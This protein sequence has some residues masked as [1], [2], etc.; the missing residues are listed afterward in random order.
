MSHWVSAALLLAV[1]LRQLEKSMR[2]I[3]G[4]GLLKHAASI[5]L[6]AYI[7]S[8]WP[9]FCG[10]VN[11]IPM[12][13]HYGAVKK[14]GTKQHAMWGLRSSIN[15]T[16]HVVCAVLCAASSLGC[17]QLNLLSCI[18]GRKAQAERR[19][20]GMHRAFVEWGSGSLACLG[21]FSRQC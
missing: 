17:M 19:L 12:H 4:M 14:D 2:L 21:S 16:W 13:L 5:D 6:H 1:A 7:D 8:I 15:L 11:P 3:Q 18:T 20:A 10:S 9:M